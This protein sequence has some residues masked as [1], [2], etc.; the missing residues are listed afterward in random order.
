MGKYNFEDDLARAK[1]DEKELAEKLEKSGVEILEVNGVTKKGDI[2]VQFP[3]RDKP[4][5]VEM[6]T[7]FMAHK[8]GNV[9]LDFAWR[10]KPSGIMTT[11]SKY[12]EYK[13]YG[14]KE[15]KIAEDMFVFFSVERLQQAC[16]D[17]A[18]FDVVNGGDRGSNTMMFRFKV[19]KFIEYG[20]V[21]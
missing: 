1:Q 13:F 14:K 9:V 4:D 6:K 21:I 7:D 16:W 2:L 17:L 18:F 8:T 10:G 5:W 15:T 3:K 11:G 12:W 20:K 19:D